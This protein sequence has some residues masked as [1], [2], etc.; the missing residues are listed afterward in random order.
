[1]TPFDTYT[2]R[3]VFSLCIF[4]GHVFDLV[5]EMLLIFAGF[6]LTPVSANLV[7]SVIS[8]LS[9]L[10]AYIFLCTGQVVSLTAQS[11]CEGIATLGISRQGSL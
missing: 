5:Q 7:P 1:M 8:S 4:I 2:K 9:Y 10:F 3:R 11:C 6:P